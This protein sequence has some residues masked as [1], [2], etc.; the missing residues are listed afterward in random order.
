MTAIIPARGDHGIDNRRDD[1]Q[2]GRR[3][4][5]TTEPADRRFRDSELHP[6]RAYTSPH[7]GV[8]SHEREGVSSPEP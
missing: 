1:G 3:G 6:T 8:R 2:P 4:H 7:G 5:E